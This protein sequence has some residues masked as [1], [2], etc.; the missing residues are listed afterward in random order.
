MTAAAPQINE[1]E[2][3]DVLLVG[4][5]P[6][7]IST[8]HQYISSLKRP[9]FRVVIA[10]KLNRIFRMIRKLK[11]ATILI[12]DRLNR[13]LM[14]RLINRLHRNPNTREIPVTL[15]KSS[16]NEFLINADFDNYVLKENLSAENLHNTI[17]SSRRLRFTSIYLYKSY[18]KSRNFLQKIWLDLRYRL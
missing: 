16:N 2:G 14:K 13:K 3:M 12:D 9:L 17:L 10:F 5:N 1:D 6:K 4:N 7:E 8:I 11:P 15:L 18:K